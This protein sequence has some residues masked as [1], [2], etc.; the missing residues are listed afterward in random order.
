MEPAKLPGADRRKRVAEKRYF[1]TSWGCCPCDPHQR[2]SGYD[3]ERMEISV[4]VAVTTQVQQC[5]GKY[6]KSIDRR[7]AN[8][9]K[10]NSSLCTVCCNP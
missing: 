8:L 3:N 6:E 1:E 9:F 7:E 4:M 10:K 5:N 2:K